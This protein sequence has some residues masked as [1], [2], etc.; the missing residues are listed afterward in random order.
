MRSLLIGVVVAMLA[1]SAR[2]GSAGA[3]NEV[4]LKM[5]FT[6]RVE[7]FTNKAGVAFAGVRVESIAPDGVT[8]WA[9]NGFKGGR[10]AIAD[11]SLET[12]ARLGVPEAFVGL[13]AEADGRKREAMINRALDQAERERAALEKSRDDQE[14]EER[15]RMIGQ[16]ERAGVF[17]GWTVNGR[18]MRLKVGA[19]FFRLDFD[20]KKTA[21]GLYMLKADDDGAAVNLVRLMDKFSN[22]EVGTFSAFGLELK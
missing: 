7:S 2:E 10:V 16:L 21:V 6:N 3:T 13:K 15:E 1:L 14:K 22:K 18:V 8:W 9:T 4:A 19:P 5:T 12:R 17:S 20:Q 11:L